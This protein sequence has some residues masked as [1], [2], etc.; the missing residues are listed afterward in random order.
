MLYTIAENI[1]LK[2]PRIH[3]GNHYTKSLLQLQYKKNYSFAIFVERHDA[4]RVAVSR[5]RTDHPG[6][7]T[8]GRRGDSRQETTV[9]H[10]ARFSSQKDNQ[11]C[12][13]RS[14]DDLGSF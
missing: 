10:T 14:H 2:N 12:R 13:R 1:F 11:K 6:W 8:S 7:H 3:Y 4:S 5:G 9:P